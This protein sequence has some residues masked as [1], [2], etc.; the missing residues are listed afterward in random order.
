M[1]PVHEH[2]DK[3]P[4]MS[5]TSS[6]TQQDYV[7]RRSVAP[8]EEGEDPL[9]VNIVLR[10]IKRQDYIC[11]L[12]DMS[13]PIGGKKLRTQFLFWDLS[14]SPPPGVTLPKGVTAGWY[15]A[16]WIPATFDPT[17][18]DPETE[19]FV[20]ADRLPQA[21]AWCHLH[22]N[23]TKSQYFCLRK[24]FAVE[25]FQDSRCNVCDF[26]LCIKLSTNQFTTSDECVFSCEFLSY[27]QI[28]V[29]YISCWYCQS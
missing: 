8:L 4:H 19:A 25:Y 11:F 15:N 6:A 28:F 22:G 21:G 24:Q 12:P 20:G 13:D 2:M 27:T 17:C 26:T 3:T 29:R 10:R 16:D 23:P 1:N 5:S 18:W 7:F 14:A 9:E